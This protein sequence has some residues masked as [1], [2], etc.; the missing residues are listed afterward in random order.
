VTAYGDNVLYKNLGDGTFQDVTE[1]AGVGDGRFGAGCSWADYDR[2]GDLDLYVTNYVTFTFRPEDRENVKKQY[3]TE[4]PYTLNPSAYPPEPNALF[5]NNGDGTFTDVAASAGVD[6]PEGKGL[7]ASW[8][9]FDNDGWVDLYVANDVSNNGV[10]RNLGNGTFADVGASSLAADYRGAMGIATGDIDNDLD[11]DL[12]VTHW[13][14]QENALFENMTSDAATIKPGQPK[15]LWFLDTADGCGLGQ[16]SLD[17][18][19]WAT[20]FADFDNDGRRDLWLVNGSTFEQTDNHRKLK[21]QV[22]F[23]FWQRGDHDFIDVAAV[24]SKRLAEPIVGRGGAHADLDQDGRLDLVLGVLGGEAII[25]RNT[26]PSAGHWLNVDL[27]QTGGNTHALGARVYVTTG[28]TTQMA[29]V[30]GSSSYLSQDE[31]TLHFGLGESSTV[32]SLEIRWPDGTEETHAAVPADQTVTYRHEAR[33][34][35]AGPITPRP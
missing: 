26:S 12:L 6:D 9:D 11:V 28:D 30:G 32:T 16:V 10:F 23:L 17:S 22:P 25:L 2:D 4:Q 15:R 21:S 29:E 34:P 13:I 31:L 7:S 35:V 19:G 1:R 14:A 18:V 20:G 24:A 8:V 33:Y 5:R 3:G 27:R